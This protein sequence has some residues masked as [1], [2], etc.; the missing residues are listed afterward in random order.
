MSGSKGL[1]KK[2]ECEFWLKGDHHLQTEPLVSTEICTGPRTQIFFPKKKMFL[3]YSQS[4]K[5]HLLLDLTLRKMFLSSLDHLCIPPGEF[6]YMAKPHL[7]SQWAFPCNSSFV[8][9]FLPISRS[10]S[11]W[12]LCVYVVESS[13]G[14]SLLI[15]YSLF[16]QSQKAHYLIE[17]VLL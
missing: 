1:M 7:L 15:C 8:W 16:S 6:P 17:C 13:W 11:F 12:R 14:S 4:P 10:L 3:I 2:P 9:L 5:L